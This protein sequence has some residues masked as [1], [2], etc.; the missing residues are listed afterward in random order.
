MNLKMLHAWSIFWSYHPW[1]NW[2]NHINI[3][4]IIFNVPKEWIKFWFYW[5]FPTNRAH[6][7]DL[8]LVLW[9]GDTSS[10]VWKKSITQFLQ[11]EVLNLSNQNTN[12]KLRRVWQKKVASPLEAPPQEFSSLE[13]TEEL[14]QWTSQGEVRSEGLTTLNPHQKS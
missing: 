10:K 5:F 14:D 3:N 7:L 6:A 13:Q 11:V 4:F 1:H 2:T 12:S 9:A 8:Y